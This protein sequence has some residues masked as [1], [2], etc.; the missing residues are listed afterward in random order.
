MR[1]IF[2]ILYFLSIIHSQ[3]RSVIFYTGVPSGYD[4]HPIYNNADSSNTVADRF[5]PMN[6]YILEGFSVWMGHVSNGGRVNAQIR[7]E[8]DGYPRQILGESQIDL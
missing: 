3:D 8:V 4:G 7:N 2:Y 5:T 1:K 6:D